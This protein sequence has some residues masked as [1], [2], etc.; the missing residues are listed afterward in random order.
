MSATALGPALPLEKY[1]DVLLV[2]KASR[3]WIHVML[4]VKSENIV[5]PALVKVENG[6]TCLV[7]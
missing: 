3:E 4:V 2:Q 6:R 7:N 5:G 1:K